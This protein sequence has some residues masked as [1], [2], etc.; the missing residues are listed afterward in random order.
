MKINNI[1][2][3]V[4]EGLGGYEFDSFED[5]II[6]SCLLYDYLYRLAASD[7]SVENNLTNVAASFAKNYKSLVQVL[8]ETFVSY[9]IMKRTIQNFKKENFL[10]LALDQIDEIIVLYR[11]KAKIVN[12]SINSFS[13]YMYKIVDMKYHQFTRLAEIH[14]EVMVPIMKYYIENHN[15]SEGDLEVYDAEV[16]A[17]NPGKCILFGIKNISAGRII[18]D[19]ERKI[20]HIPYFSL[21]M[22]GSYVKIITK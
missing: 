16:F 2:K 5:R 11:N 7:S 1:K 12:F 9:T 15:L 13:Q 10:L 18:G 22:Q 4:Y 21:S 8:K 14:N 19:I 20:I 3:A 6:A 17:D